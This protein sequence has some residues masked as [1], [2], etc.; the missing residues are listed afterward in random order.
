[1][2]TVLGKSEATLTMITDNLESLKQFSEIKIINNLR[3]S[4]SLEYVNNRFDYSE[5]HELKTKE[6]CF[7]IG[8]TKPENKIVIYNFFG[9]D[10]NKFVNIIH[11]SSQISSTA[12]INNGAII[13]F[14]VSVAGY[15]K[16]GNHVTINRNSSIGHHTII[17]DFVA[18]NPGC[19]IAG[20]CLIGEGTLIGM[21][22][23]VRDGV[24]IGKNCTI[25]MGSTVL[26]DIPDNS[27]VF[28]LIK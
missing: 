3:K 26:K 27:K 1:M 12:T 23:N 8:V 24:K 15:A 14:L 25:G 20:N 2:I 10:N 21:G 4:T 16:L 5:E 18:I 13:N 7:I 17:E 11:T 6:G 28:G 9:V 22:T 19:N